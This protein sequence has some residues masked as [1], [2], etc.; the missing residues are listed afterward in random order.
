[1]NTETSC[2]PELASG[3]GVARHETDTAVE[4][5]RRM[6]ERYALEVDRF[7]PRARASS[8]NCWT[9]AR[10]MPSPRAVGRTN[11]RLISPTVAL[12][13]LRPPT[14]TA[15]PSTSAT[16]AALP[17]RAASSS[18][19]AQMV[20]LGGRTIPSSTLIRSLTQTPNS[21]A[22]AVRARLVSRLDAPK[23][24]LPVGHQSNLADSHEQANRRQ[25]DSE[26]AAY[27][28]KNP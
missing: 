1:M 7:Q 12:K 14:P 22:S 19:A 3:V 16:R 5:V 11:I 6:H 10:P 15:S 18:T 23:A 20:G 9:I 2:L 4:S 13:S 26:R 24:Y 25:A 8:I 27:G 21:R 17:I 28:G